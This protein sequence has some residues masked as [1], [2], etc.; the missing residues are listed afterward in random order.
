MRDGVSERARGKW[1]RP[2]GQKFGGGWKEG[3]SLASDFVPRTGGCVG[4]V[5]WLV[6]VSAK[7]EGVGG[8]TY[9]NTEVSPT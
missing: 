8:W 1:R 4:V 9:L 2:E 5:Q 3:P 6:V 7:T